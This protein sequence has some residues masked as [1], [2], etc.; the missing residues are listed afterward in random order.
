MI[1]DGRQPD[2][3]AEKAGAKA[4]MRLQHP[5]LTDHLALKF[6]LQSSRFAEQPSP[7]LVEDEDRVQIRMVFK[8]RG[9][10][11][12]RNQDLPDRGKMFAHETKGGGRD[13]DIAEKT[14]LQPDDGLEGFKSRIDFIHQDLQSN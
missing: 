9:S 3:S 6:G 12:R 5:S 1:S 2:E 7:A 14:R 11:R 8:G 4:S 10:D 13:N